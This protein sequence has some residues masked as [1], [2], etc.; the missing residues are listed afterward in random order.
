[1]RIRSVSA[2]R[3]ECKEEECEEKRRMGGLNRGFCMM[4]CM[5]CVGVG[6]MYLISLKRRGCG[7]V[8][9]RS[10]NHQS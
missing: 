4:L 3:R 9:C 8:K 1:M 10:Y 5:G 7:S 6:C 2:R